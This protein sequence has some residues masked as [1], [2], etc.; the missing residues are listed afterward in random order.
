MLFSI[1]VK[2]LSSALRIYSQPNSGDILVV[3][4]KTIQLSHKENLAVK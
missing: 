4:N 2:T 1:V 3:S